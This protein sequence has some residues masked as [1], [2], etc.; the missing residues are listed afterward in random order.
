MAEDRSAAEEYVTPQS[1]YIV[2][3]NRASVIK[4]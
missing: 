4:R 3:P 2:L 1:E